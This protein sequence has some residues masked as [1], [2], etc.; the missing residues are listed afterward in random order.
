MLKKGASILTTLGNLITAWLIAS[1]SLVFW[2]HHLE[3][4]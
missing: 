2:G 4:E 1:F 3:K